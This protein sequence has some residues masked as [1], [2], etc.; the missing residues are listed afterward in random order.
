MLG[1]GNPNE[2]NFA[3]IIAPKPLPV[4]VSIWWAYSL[5]FEAQFYAFEWA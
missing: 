3:A 5:G 1:M 4:C 2:F